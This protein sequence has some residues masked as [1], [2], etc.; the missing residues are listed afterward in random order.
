MN[1]VT[2]V[3]IAFLLLTFNVVDQAKAVVSG[4][5]TQQEA[6]LSEVDNNIQPISPTSTPI[7]TP[8][9]SPTPTAIPTPTPQ[10]RV[11]VQLFDM[12]WEYRGFPHVCDVWAIP[13]LKEYE[14]VV[15]ETT[16]TYRECDRNNS[17]EFFAFSNECHKNSGCGPDDRECKKKC[18]ERVNEFSSGLLEKCKEP[19]N[20]IWDE[21]SRLKA[22]AHCD[23]KIE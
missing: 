13:K 16:K 17:D 10:P 4:S 11:E 7:P 22:E 5:N 2:L 8:T 9:A 21:W 1:I 19:A 20:P 18:S 15:E 14:K 3:Q 6:V 12:Q 23:L